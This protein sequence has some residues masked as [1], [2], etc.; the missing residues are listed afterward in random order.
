MRKRL[1]L[2]LDVPKYWLVAHDIG[3]CVAF[4]VALRYQD[5]LHGVAAIAAEGGLR[6]FLA[7]TPQT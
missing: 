2:A 1:G 6:A 7:A 3:A 5:R 4:S